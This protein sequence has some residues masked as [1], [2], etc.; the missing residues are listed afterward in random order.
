MALPVSRRQMELLNAFRTFTQTHGHTPSVRELAKILDRAAST[1]H[2]TLSTLARK[3]YMRN[4]GGAHG[5]QLNEER[6]V[7]DLSDGGMLDEAFESL[8]VAAVAAVAAAAAEAG[9][10]DSSRAKGS[11]RPKLV[12]EPTT[13]PPTEMVEVPIR[14]S[15]AAGLPIEAID[16]PSDTLTLPASQVPTDAYALRVSGNSMI[17]DHIL[18]GDLVLVEPRTT[19]PDGEIAVALLED[20]TATLK[21]IY[22]DQARRQIRLQPANAEMD[23][24]WVDQVTIQGRAIGVLR[25]WR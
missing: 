5:W 24:F 15:I 22:R 17:E 13:E 1:I 12:S 16:D 6:L 3:G 23:P 14:G 21:R 20:G 10:A 2:Q 8:S 19:V 18:D 11:N 7:A 25:M 9:D 4:E